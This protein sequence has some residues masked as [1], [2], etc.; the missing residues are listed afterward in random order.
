MGTSIPIDRPPVI[1]LSAYAV[2]AAW[3]AWETDTVLLP[4]AYVDKVYAAGGLPVLLPP[5]PGVIEQVLPRL[6]GLLL[7]GGPDLE[8]G[9]YGQPPGPRTQPP[10]R[11]RDEAEFRLLATAVD[12]GL[13][14][15]GICRGM[16]LLNVARGGT[17]VQHL[18]DVVDADEHAPGP[19]VYGSHPVQVATGTRLSGLLGPALDGVPSYHHQ[20]VQRLGDGLVATAWAPDGTVEALEDPGLPFCVAVQWHPEM[21]DDPRLFDGLV[22][23]ARRV[24][25]AGGSPDAP[26]APAAG[27]SADGPDAPAAGGSADGPDAPVRVRA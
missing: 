24:R 11:E 8:P 17:L 14:V 22:A 1:G 23:A 27:G 13:P 18:P 20:G 15:L 5:L 26:D 2:P 10:S 16:Q 25:D 4:R 19:G 6:D 21:G 12:D 7:A 3:A 9:R